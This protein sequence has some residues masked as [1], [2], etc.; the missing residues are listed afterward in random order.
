MTN[1]TTM[2]EITPWYERKRKPPLTISQ[3]AKLIEDFMSGDYSIKQLAKLYVISYDTAARI[4][5]QYWAKPERELT[6]Q[7]KV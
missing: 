3:Q 6:L 1:T 2:P 4:I 5:S 7:S